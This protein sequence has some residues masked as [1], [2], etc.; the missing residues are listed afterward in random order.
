MDVQER[1][2]RAITDIV[3]LCVSICITDVTSYLKNK[4]K[5]ATADFAL[6]FCIKK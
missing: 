3:N 6:F 2:T 1:I 5:P 4:A